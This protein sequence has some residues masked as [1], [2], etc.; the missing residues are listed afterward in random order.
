MGCCALCVL[1]AFLT[2]ERKKEKKNNKRIERRRRIEMGRRRAS[3]WR[4]TSRRL[5]MRNWERCEERPGPPSGTRPHGP[6]MTAKIKIKIIKNGFLYMC[7]KGGY[8]VYNG[9]LCC[10]KRKVF[11]FSAIRQKKKKKK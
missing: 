9:L 1:F 2:G 6:K 3:D 4:G 11:S 10:L 8:C 7:V 5:T